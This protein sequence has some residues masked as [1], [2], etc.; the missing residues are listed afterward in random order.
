MHTLGVAEY[1]TSG[2]CSLFCNQWVNSSIVLL[3]LMHSGNK[4]E[5]GQKPA[6][7]I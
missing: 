1:L 4:K 3:Q 6:N 5:L 7:G 2:V